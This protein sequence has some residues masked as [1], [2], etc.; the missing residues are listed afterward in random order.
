MPSA[1]VT[2]RNEGTGA[3]RHVLTD[4]QGVY[5]ASELPVGYYRVRFAAPGLNTL[6]RLRVKVDVGGETRADAALSAQSL[7]Q[8]VAVNADAPVLQQDSSALAEVV[9][10]RQV[11]DT[12]AERSRFS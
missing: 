3:E 4:A 8:S 10:T 1:A 12:A 11:G 7:E 5:V 9:D 6:E 2:V